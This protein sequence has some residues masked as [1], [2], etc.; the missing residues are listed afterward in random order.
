MEAIGIIEQQITN[1]REKVDILKVYGPKILK[2]SNKSSSQVTG[3]NYKLNQ[4]G[5]ADRLVK[6]V[7]SIADDVITLAVG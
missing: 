2:N 6:L 4:D 5:Q 7:R 1:I 3:I